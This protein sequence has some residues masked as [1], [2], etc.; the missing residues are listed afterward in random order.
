[1]ASRFKI[2]I[3]KQKEIEQAIPNFTPEVKEGNPQEERQKLLQ[4]LLEQ[5]IE[6]TKVPVVEEKKPAKRP[7]KW[8]LPYYN[9]PQDAEEDTPLQSTQPQSSNLMIRC[10]NGYDAIIP[11]RFLKCSLSS[12]G[13]L[14][15]KFDGNI[16][17]NIFTDISNAK[18]R[19]GQPPFNHER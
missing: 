14:I 10:P 19:L 8:P 17:N 2:A 18:R 12:N 6:A 1:M 13:D 16:A 4:G 3:R 9:I 7:K 15:L 5:A 11:T